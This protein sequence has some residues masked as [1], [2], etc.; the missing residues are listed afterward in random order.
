MKKYIV[1]LNEEERIQLTEM[2]TKGK[3][4]AYKIR[5]ANILLKVDADGPGWTDGVTGKAFSAHENTVSGIRRRFV[6]EGLQSALERKKQTVSS[7]KPKLDGEGEARLIAL[8]CGLPPEGYARW[9][10]RLLQINWWNW[11][12]SGLF[13]MR[14]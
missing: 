10:L 13:H 3:T 7:R 14:Q 6:E 12:S 11:K 5:H 8:G 4:A 9:N 2:I 1:R